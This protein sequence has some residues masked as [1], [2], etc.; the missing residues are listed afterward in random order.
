MRRWA[1][2]WLAAAAPA[3]R[4]L[5]RGVKA[6][7]RV[8]RMQLVDDVAEQALLDQLLE[9][10]K[11]P[12]SPHARGA[13]YL[14]FTPFRYAPEWPSRFRRPDEAGAWYGADDPQTVA[15]ELARWRW[16]FLVDS[17]ALRETQLVTEHTFFRA[18]FTGLELDV[19]AP[20]WSAQ[21]TTWR[22]PDEYAPCQEVAAQARALKPPVQV[23][24]YESARRDGGA[25][26]AVFDV[27]TLRLSRQPVQQTWT[28]K[29]TLDRVLWSH[30]SGS[31]QFEMA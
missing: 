13:H 25:C 17:H 10:S 15:A 12:L 26:E 9:S 29:T 4:E 19:T 6:Q 5:W 30:E 23:I 7:H 27:R 1:R 2:K 8:A 14:L 31:L 28:C 24:R 20:P 22:D 18:R 11:P 21:R 16:K 3:R